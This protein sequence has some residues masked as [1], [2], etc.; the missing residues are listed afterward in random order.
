MF[1]PTRMASSFDINWYLGDG[2]LVDTTPLRLPKWLIK[3]RVSSMVT[4]RTSNGFSDY[5]WYF[6]TGMNFPVSDFGAGAVQRD[7]CTAR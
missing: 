7:G 2:S 3:V 6:D 4:P 5:V 1:T